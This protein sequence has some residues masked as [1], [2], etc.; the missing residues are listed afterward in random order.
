MD[1][2]PTT[3]T[4]RRPGGTS[5]ADGVKTLD[6]ADAER[7]NANRVAGPG[8]I[9]TEP[10]TDAMIR[11]LRDEA[12]AAGDTDMVTI[13]D[14]A[15]AGDDTARED[16]ADAI[17]DDRAMDDERVMVRVVAEKAGA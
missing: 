12:A 14:S 9:I 11:A 3:Y 15:L 4:I 17:N 5:W 16:V 13:C 8:H 6:E 10:L 2:A 1:D 7:K